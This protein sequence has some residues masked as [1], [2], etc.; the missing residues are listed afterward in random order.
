M[1]PTARVSS[2]K[3]RGKERDETIRALSTGVDEERSTGEIKNSR[4]GT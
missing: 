1:L 4:K 2:I 3:W